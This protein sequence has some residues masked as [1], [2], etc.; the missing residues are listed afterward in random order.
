[1]NLGSYEQ[2]F[3]HNMICLAT[4]RKRGPAHSAAAQS[5]SGGPC[6]PLAIFDLDHTLI[7]GD[8]NALWGEFLAA[9]G[10]VDHEQFR[11]LSAAFDE[12][13]RDGRLDISRYSRFMLEP[14]A[15][16]DS[17][18]L[19][20]WLQRFVTDCVRPAIPP[21][22][23]RLLE[24]HRAAGDTLI[25]ITASIRP[26]TEPIATDLGVEH[27]LATEAVR[28]DGHYTGEVWGVPTYREGKVHRLRSWLT[29]NAATLAGSHFYS[30]SHNDLPLLE[31]V[32]HPVAVNPDPELLACARNRGWPVIDLR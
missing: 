24:R 23:R 7:D 30:D 13:Y 6:V 29:D 5:S 26:I 31:Q 19:N 2:T 16:R 4:F 25:I 18:V 1:M 12:D 32:D 11:R 14:I 15:R 22:A 21:A 27:L 3:F 9:Q 28:K 17:T 8:S 10:M 20:D